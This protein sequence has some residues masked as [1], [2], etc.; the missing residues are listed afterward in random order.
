MILVYILCEFKKGT[1]FNQA[2]IS[3]HGAPLQAL[4][5]RVK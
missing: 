3:V 2:I 1:V 5:Y 4:G